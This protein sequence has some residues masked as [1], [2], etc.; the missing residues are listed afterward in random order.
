MFSNILAIIIYSIGQKVLNYSLF[1]LIVWE[2]FKTI[3]IGEIEVMRSANKN[4]CF[5]KKVFTYQE[6][7]LMLTLPSGKAEI[8][9]VSDVN[10][11]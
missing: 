10:C 2:I 5:P 7:I 4:F 9:L 8:I 1:F 6:I 11:Q 3:H